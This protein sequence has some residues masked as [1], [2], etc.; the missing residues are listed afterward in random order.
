MIPHS[1]QLLVG[2]A[3]NLRTGQLMVS[4]RTVNPRN[5]G[6]SPTLSTSFGGRDEEASTEQCCS[7]ISLFHFS[8]PST[9]STR[10]MD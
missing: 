8:F 10:S 5:V 6:S 9:S 7:V 3:D 1:S 4:S 2:I